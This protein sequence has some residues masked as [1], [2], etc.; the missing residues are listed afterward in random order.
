MSDE[1]IVVNTEE[2][3]VSEVPTEKPKKK[4]MKE[5]DPEIFSDLPVQ[6]S[7]ILG[8]GSM[9]FRQLAALSEE[10]VIELD[11]PLNGE[12]QLLLGERVV[13]KGEI[14]SVDN[15]FAVRITQTFIRK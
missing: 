14:V 5:I 1:D 10:D 13:A 11:T 8:R 7:A 6:I 12:V 9:N 15:R 3:N 2:K 4:I